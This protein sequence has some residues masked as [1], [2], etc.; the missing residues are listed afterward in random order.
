VARQRDQL[1]S[2]HALVVTVQ[3]HYGRI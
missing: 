3:W 2:G 1:V